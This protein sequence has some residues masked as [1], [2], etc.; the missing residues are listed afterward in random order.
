MENI[1]SQGAVIALV[2]YLL[3]FV[4]L[5]AIWGIL[6]LSKKFFTRKTDKVKEEAITPPPAPKAE[7]KVEIGEDEEELIA[8]LTAAVAASLGRTSTYNLNIKSYRRV[9]SSSPAWNKISRQEN[10][11]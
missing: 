11:S 4:V 5:S 6:E 10:L 1:L 8:V 9:G 7:T 3:V 2:G